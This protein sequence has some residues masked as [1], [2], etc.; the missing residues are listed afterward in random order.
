M[1]VNIISINPTTS[2][3]LFRFII[4]FFISKMN[5]QVEL[6]EVHVKSFSNYYSNFKKL[7]FNTIS[8]YDTYQN[9]MSQSAISKFSK[10]FKVISNVFQIHQSK[11]KEIIYTCDYQVLFF[12]LLINS[13]LKRNNVI[14]IYHQFELIEKLKLTGLN[15]FFYIYILKKSGRINLAIFPEQNRLN[16]FL[17][18]SII[19]RENTFILPNTCESITTKTKNKHP[20]F[21]KFPEGAFIVAH[22]GNVGGSQHYFN[23]FISATQNLIDH[24]NI[25][26]LFLGRINNTIRAIINDNT[27]PN[28]VFIDSVPHEELLQIYPHIDLG[29]ILYKG[30]GLNYE[31]CAP[32]KLY[33]LWSNGV[34]VIAHELKGLTPIFDCKEK[35]ILTDFE[36]SNNI[37]NAI[38]DYSN[39]IN[40][41][42]E[43][44]I[45]KFTK[46][47]AIDNFFSLLQPKIEHLIK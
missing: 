30:N 23:N 7:S 13:I 1:K 5:A 38:L 47:Y 29:A 32:N 24:K 28:L 31:F 8:R 3:P 22:L 43:T 44:L 36:V 25:A 11:A 15:K 19:K 46:D 27:N 37:S 34:P 42:K 39:R 41:E 40:K 9:F 14:I 17:S 16:Y 26:F 6:S 2:I 20:L 18:E 45:N 10:Y 12:A 33:E 21:N 35:G 4:D